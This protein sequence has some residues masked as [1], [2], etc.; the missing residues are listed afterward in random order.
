MA[1][2]IRTG[3]PRRFNK[4]RSSTFRE[5]FRVRQSPEE[6][7]KTY[8]PKRRGNNNKDEDN[9]PKTLNDKN[10]FRYVF[11]PV[12]WFHHYSQTQTFLFDINHFVCTQ[13][14]GF[15]CCYL[16]LI[17][18][19]N[20]VSLICPKSNGSTCCYVITIILFC[21]QVNCFKYSI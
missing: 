6:G 5:S 11:N 20:S 13:W 21:I 15:K 19:F 3:D 14:S 2:G 1:I 12:K 16:T 4:G 8:W 9:S 18:L 7:R 17:I 10:K